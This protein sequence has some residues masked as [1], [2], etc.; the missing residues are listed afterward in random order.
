MSSFDDAF[1][2]AGAEVGLQCWRI[3]NKQVVAVSASTMHQ[4]HSGDSY[5]FLKTM[6]CKRAKLT[7]NIHFWLG[8]DTSVDEMGIAA[9]KTVELDTMLNGSPIQ[10]RELQHQE[11]TQFLSYFKVTGL[12]YLSGGVESGFAHVTAD[13]YPLRLFHVKG[14]RTVR[15]IQVPANHSS[16]NQNDV[17]L[18]DNGLT[19]Y[20]F[21]GTNANRMEKTKGADVIRQIKNDERGGR[22]SV[23]FMDE[24]PD[25]AEFWTLLGA[26]NGLPVTVLTPPEMVSDDHVPPL[27]VYE[28]NDDLQVENELVV[29][30]LLSKHLLTDNMMFLIDTSHLVFVWVG[31]EVASSQRKQAIPA[32]MKY[33]ESH[34]LPLRTPIVRILQGGETPHF[35]AMFHVWSPPKVYDFRLVDTS[36]PP[37]VSQPMDIDVEELR[38]IREAAEEVVD[39][40]TGTLSIWRIED[41][42]K[43]PL[44]ESQYGQFYGGDSYIVHYSYADETGGINSLLY[45]WQGRNSSTDEKAA[46]ALLTVDLDAHGASDSVQI[47]VMQGKE[48]T[49][50]KRLFKGKMIVH[51]GGRH[52]GF[53]NSVEQDTYDTDGISLFQ[54]KGTSTL[55]TCASQVP[56]VAG[57]LNSGDVFVLMTPENIFKWLGKASSH[58]EASVASILVDTYFTSN[59][60]PITDI[61]E[62]DEPEPFWTALGGQAD[63]AVHKVGITLPQAPR[64]FECSNS[65]GKFACVEIADFAQDDL[66]V[67]DV[68]LLDTVTSLYTWI[69]SGA[70]V[71]EIRA[72]EQLSKKYLTPERVANVTMVTITCQHEPAMFTCNFLG[73]D[74]TYFEKSAFT[75]PYETKLKLLK[76]EKLQK[77]QEL[78]VQV[79][80]QKIQV[81]EP[82]PSSSSPPPPSASLTNG[83]IL[84]YEELKVATNIDTTRKQDFLSSEEFQNVFGMDKAAFDAL[85]KWKQQ[86]KKKEVGLF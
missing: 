66:N 85:P 21:N 7:H 28:L 6:D 44:P 84:T 26:S 78:D 69:G 14:K 32:A 63:Y 42:E 8:Q 23:I 73:W 53:K 50:F 67:D 3:E 48:P 46:S 65:S 20:L 31:E 51:L 60:V 33:L 43:V 12:Q 71:Q 70:N 39:D 19:L 11:S 75:D 13:T 29:T 34:D 45:F 86:A 47:R 17:F 5:I 10:Y 79:D 2:N 4:L 16:L 9:Y 41:M 54:I 49:H 37:A 74:K 18:L 83:A 81:A 30:G 25:N 80:S 77:M 64:L 62:G 59:G 24:E 68:Y 72:A 82:T 27:K 35:K 1:E 58:E 56:E 57:S 38:E 61:A 36:G 40:G 15:V 76:A 55:N 22:A 52:S